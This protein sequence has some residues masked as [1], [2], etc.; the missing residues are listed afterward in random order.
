MDD[1]HF[2]ELL[3]DLGYAFEGYRRVRKGVKKRLRRH[4]RD[5]GCRDMTAY[6]ER[7]AVSH[8]VR[9]T[10]LRRMAVPISR[11]MRDHRFWDA[12]GDT[13][14]P[15]LQRRFGPRLRAW[16]AG[17]ACGEEA[18]S[19]AIIG[20]ER[21]LRQAPVT[22]LGVAITATDINPACLSKA[23]AGIYPASSLREMPGHLIDRYFRPLRRGRRYQIKSDLSREILWCCRR[24]ECP[25]P[26][27]AYHLVMLR[28]NILTYYKPA[29]QTTVLAK[30]LDSLHPDGLF[31]VGYR[32]RLPADFHFMEP[33]TAE[34]PYVYR[35]V[36]DQH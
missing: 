24:V 15:D 8:D 4:M 18:Y 19:L 1:A 3:D 35:K 12:L 14:L 6:R 30:V 26:E 27:H 29:R 7:I 2:R 33:V 13:W 21:R 32:E 31:V 17:C 25:L 11:F 5:L 9:E 10:C 28:N 22:D 16:A 20:R 23:R 34:F 36:S